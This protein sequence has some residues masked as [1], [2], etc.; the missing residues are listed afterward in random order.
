MTKSRRVKV[1]LSL[2]EDLVASVDRRARSEPDGTRSAVVE[3]LL[4]SG[5]RALAEA[6]LRSEVIA[7]YAS[8]DSDERR[9]NEAI[10][11]ASSRAAHRLDVNDSKPRPS[12]KR[13]R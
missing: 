10:A 5:E 4:R 12:W 2:P 3:A 9:E 1:S 11:R 7:Y 8:L 6:D 13:S